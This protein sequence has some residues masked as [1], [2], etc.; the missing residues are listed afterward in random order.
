MGISD[1]WST[2]VHPWDI[3]MIEDMWNEYTIISESG[4]KGLR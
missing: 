4:L 1:L 3:F 2:L